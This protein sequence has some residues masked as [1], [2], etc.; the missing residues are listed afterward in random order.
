[1]PLWSHF[2]TPAWRCSWLMPSPSLLSPLHLLA[3]LMLKLHDLLSPNFL[4]LC[5]YISTQSLSQNAKGSSEP[6]RGMWSTKVAPSLPVEGVPY[7]P[8]ET[9]SMAPCRWA[10]GWGGG[11][12]FGEKSL[13]ESCLGSPEPVLRWCQSQPHL[14]RD[15]MHIVCLYCPE[16]D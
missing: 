11:S 6:Q 8:Q 13:G 7:T 2:M 14:W 16:P 9:L 3:H 10:R 12:S 1:M 15:W 4:C 5:F